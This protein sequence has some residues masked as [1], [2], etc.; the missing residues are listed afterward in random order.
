MAVYVATTRVEVLEEGGECVIRRRAPD[1]HSGHRKVD[2]LAARGRPSASLAAQ[3]LRQGEA[4]EDNRWSAASDVGAQFLRGPPEG[5]LQVL[6]TPGAVLRE[7][8]NLSEA[9]ALPRSARLD[10]VA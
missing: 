4:A 8:A 6:T 10:V 9:I 1:A 5:S 2:L 3:A 7:P